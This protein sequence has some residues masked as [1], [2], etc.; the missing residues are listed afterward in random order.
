MLLFDVTPKGTKPSCMGKKIIYMEHLTLRLAQSIQ[1]AVA[2]LIPLS[3]LDLFCVPHI[4][5]KTRHLLIT[6]SYT[7]TS[8]SIQHCTKEGVRNQ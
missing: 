7:T 1:R 2:A 6:V 5:K 8:H 3:I 4:L